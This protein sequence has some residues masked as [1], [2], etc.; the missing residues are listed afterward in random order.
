MIRNGCLW[1]TGL[2]AAGKTTVSE[3]VYSRLKE[4]HKNVILLDGDQLRRVFN[5]SS[6]SYDRA[7]RVETGLMYSRLIKELVDQ[8]LFIIIA[9]IGLY[10]EVHS[11][12]RE[13]IPH[14]VDTLLEVPLEELEARDPKGIYKKYRNGLINNIAGLDLAVDYPPAPWLHVKWQQGM[15]PDQIADEI[16]NKLLDEHTDQ[17]RI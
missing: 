14:F 4:Q 16:I 8:G 7:A 12:N 3:I 9:V 17:Y 6:N 15:M 11:W 5:K 2:S 10:E 13:N 1:I